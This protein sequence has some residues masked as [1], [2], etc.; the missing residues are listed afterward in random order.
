[1]LKYAPLGDLLG[2]PLLVVRRVLLRGRSAEVEGKVT[3]ATGTI[4]IASSVRETP[5]AWWI[6]TRALGSVIY[7]IPYCLKRR[8]PVRAPDFELPLK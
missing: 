4:G 2:M 8:E 6:L 3:D 1:M 5:G 7:N